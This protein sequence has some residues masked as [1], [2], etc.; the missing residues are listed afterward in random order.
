MIDLTDR[1]HDQC[2]FETRVANQLRT[3][4]Q[5]ARTSLY[6]RVYD[7]YAE[8]FPEHLPKD[9][10]DAERIARYETLFL[11]RFL[12]PS[13]TMIEVGPGKCHLAF[14][15][16]PLVAKIYGVDVAAESPRTPETPPNF[17]WRP[18]D[19]IHMPF[20][21][22]SIDFVFSNQL[23]EHLHPDDAMAQLREIHRVLRKGGSYI[24]VTPS[25]INGPHDCSAYFDDL[26]CP[27]QAGDYQATGL[28]LKEYT[29]RELLALF[30]DANF[31]SVQAWIGARGRYIA[32]PSAIITSVEAMLRMIPAG[33]R[34]RSRILSVILGNRVYA[35]K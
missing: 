11:R 4:G 29:T 9:S 12:S 5:K 10:K 26:P 32:L 20:D 22:D 15:I 7:E 6:S 8:Q 35:T 13:T 3:V 24:C 17:E 19:G 1:V 16:A 33:R 18:T 30:K 34:K 28:H 27:I 25:R 14:A 31:R 23:M 21:S 2:V